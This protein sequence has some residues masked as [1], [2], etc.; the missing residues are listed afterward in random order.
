M[1]P[2]IQMLVQDAAAGKF[3]EV[4]AEALDRISRDQED[5]AAEFKRLSFAGIKINTLS[6]GEISQLHIFLKGTMNALFLKELTEKTLRALRGRVEKG[7]SCGGKCY[8]YDVVAG[9][10]RGQ[11]VVNE[12]DAAVVDASLKTTHPRNP[13][14][15]SLSNS[16]KRVF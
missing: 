6:E 10:E 2:G 4:V 8:G 1:R 13:L 16:T 11:R 7:R 9:E 14:R 5:I 3:E 15:P 12:A